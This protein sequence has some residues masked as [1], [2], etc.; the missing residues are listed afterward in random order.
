MTVATE[1]VSLELQRLDVVCT[2]VVEKFKVF[3]F[4]GFSYLTTLSVAVHADYALWPL[5]S[6][7]TNESCSSNRH[8]QMTPNNF[9]F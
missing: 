5:V 1:F 7:R 4:I 6:R 9:V 8:R 3:L 2:L